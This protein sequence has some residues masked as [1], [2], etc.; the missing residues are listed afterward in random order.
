MLDQLNKNIGKELYIMLENNNSFCGIVEKVLNPQNVLLF[1]VSS[2]V[3]TIP[4]NK[5]IYFR[6]T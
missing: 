3:V 1:K 6:A 2:K 5:I 4:I